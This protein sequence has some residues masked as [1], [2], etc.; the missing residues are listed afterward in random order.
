M[1]RTLQIENFRALREFRMS[2]LG[3]VNLLVGTNNSGKTTVLEA[4]HLLLDCNVGTLISSQDRRE[5]RSASG[6]WDTAQVFHGRVSQLGSTF[7]IR[8]DDCSM[9]ARVGPYDRAVSFSCDWNRD[10]QPALVLDIEWWEASSPVSVIKAPLDVNGGLLGSLVAWGIVRG[11]PVEFVSTKGI[12]STTAAEWL[13]DVL[14]TNDEDLVLD[15]LRTIE[16]ALNRIAAVG[17][18]SKRAEGRIAVNVRGERMPLGSMG[19]GMSRLLGIALALVRAKGGVLLVDEIDTGLHYSVLEKMWK[20]VFEA[21]Q[22][23]DVQVFATTHSRD[24]VEALAGIAQ[25]DRHEISI[26]RIE[27]GKPEAIAYSEAAILVAAERG[28]EVR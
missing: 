14:L 25:R 28:I 9:T 27:H 20:L 17:L 13:G 4:I 5:E 8:S 2:G 16:P 24:C 7:S 15:A 23:L 10:E 21:A 18:T 11:R 26:Q 3:R 1:I 19:D 6:S 22:R 12:A